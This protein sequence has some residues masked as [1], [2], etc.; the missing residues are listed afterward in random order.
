MICLLR[1]A[2][3]LMD[4]DVLLSYVSKLGLPQITSLFKDVPCHPLRKKSIKDLSFTFHGEK[5][6]L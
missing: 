5:K 1:K 3:H 2:E 6:N 4:L